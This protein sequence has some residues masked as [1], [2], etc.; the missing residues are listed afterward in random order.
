MKTKLHLE[1]VA[2]AIVSGS[3]LVVGVLTKAGYACADANT[4]AA[5]KMMEANG[6]F[7]FWFNRYQSLLGNVLTAAVAGVTLFWIARQLEVSHRESAISAASAL[8]VRTAELTDELALCHDLDSLVARELSAWR[9]YEQKED[10]LTEKEIAA[11]TVA[12]DEIAQTARRFEQLN[13]AHPGGYSKH[14]RVRVAE[15]AKEC[16]SRNLEFRRMTMTMRSG[17]D[18]RHAAFKMR[19]S[20][21]TLGECN[22]DLSKMLDTE[23]TQTWATIRQLEA[24]AVS[25][26]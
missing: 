26:R 10:W 5:M 19:N 2:F 7:E 17:S 15:V 12:A 23:L 18:A 3:A 16:R 14:L 8:R 4:F 13:L 1:I 22:S 21:R 24:R 20:L 6:C 25:T 9:D 11:L